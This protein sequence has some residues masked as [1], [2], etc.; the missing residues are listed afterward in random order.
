[1]INKHGRHFWKKSRGAKR[2]MG[3]F[4]LTCLCFS[5]AHWL[6]RQTPITWLFICMDEQHLICKK[7][8]GLAA[9]GTL[10]NMLS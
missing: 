6:N 5:D 7:I 3:F 8:L 2:Y 4:F 9:S 10:T 1:M